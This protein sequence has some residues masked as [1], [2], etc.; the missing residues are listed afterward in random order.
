[1]V[2]RVDHEIRASAEAAFDAM[3]KVRNELRWNSRVSAAGERASS[4]S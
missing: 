1:M 3:T 2:F 4:L